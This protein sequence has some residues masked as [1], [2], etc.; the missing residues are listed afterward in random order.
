[1]KQGRFKEVGTWAD[2]L[3]AKKKVKVNNKELFQSC[4]V[5]CSSIWCTAQIMQ[6]SETRQAILDHRDLPLSCAE[7]NA[8]THLWPGSLHS[9][10]CYGTGHSWQEGV[11]PSQEE[12]KAWACDCS[13]SLKHRLTNWPVVDFVWWKKCLTG[14]HWRISG[15]TWRLISFVVLFAFLTARRESAHL[16]PAKLYLGFGCK[17]ELLLSHRLSERSG[18]R[19][20]SVVFCLTMFRSVLR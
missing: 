9:V 19:C 5:S 8:P 3:R 12:M 18:R 16:N 13:C 2:P 10:P 1:M 7:C 14:G 6:N 20:Y 15:L 11:R 4:A 17:H